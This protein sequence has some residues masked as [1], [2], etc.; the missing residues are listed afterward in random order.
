MIQDPRYCKECG[1]IEAY[2]ID[3]RT[4]RFGRC[5]RYQCCNPD[6]KDRWTTYELRGDESDSNS[7][8][9]DD[10]AALADQIDTASKA[11]NQMSKSVAEMRKRTSRQ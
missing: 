6:C 5:R 11:L 8:L 3:S 2:V 4:S 7:Q 10:L 9:M 1:N